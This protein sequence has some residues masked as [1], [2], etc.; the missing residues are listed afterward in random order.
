[1]KQIFVLF[2]V[3]LTI[4]QYNLSSPLY[5]NDKGGIFLDYYLIDL[6]TG[7]FISL[8]YIGMSSDS[9]KF[10]LVEDKENAAKFKY[11]ENAERYAVKYK[12]FTKKE[13]Q[14]IEIYKDKKTN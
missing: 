9:I 12:N 5:L 11:E 3:L 10:S 6:E 1:M 14:V 4:L 7:H 2:H 8:K 13:A